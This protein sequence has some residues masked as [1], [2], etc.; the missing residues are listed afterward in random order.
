MGKEK[1]GKGREEERKERGKERKKK[2]RK[3]ERK[4]EKKSKD[5]IC[6]PNWPVFD[7]YDTG[8]GISEH[9]VVML[10]PSCPHCG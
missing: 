4:K 9:N 5:K 1:E 6:D 7:S 10:Q 8:M 2:E 3:K